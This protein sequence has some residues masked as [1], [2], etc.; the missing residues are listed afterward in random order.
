MKFLKAALFLLITLPSFSAVTINVTESGSD[1]L[2]THNGNLNITGLTLSNPN[3]S[4]ITWNVYPQSGALQAGSSVNRDLY[5]GLVSSGG[6]FG[7]GSFTA[8][9]SSDGDH[10]YVSTGFISLP[11]SFISGSSLTG[12]NTFT[13]ASFA[14]LGIAAGT[15]VWTLPNDTITV[16]FTA[17]AVPEPSTYAMIAGLSMLGF[18]VLRRRG[19]KNRQGSASNSG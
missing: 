1:V 12:S 4:P 13:G 2:M 16:N 6:S 7:S 18:V 8:A 10:V 14:S 5:N 19:G 3:L 17:S 11:V 15:Y 9:T